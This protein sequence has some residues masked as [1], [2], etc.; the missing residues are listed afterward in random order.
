MET[1]QK[2][3]IFDPHSYG[4]QRFFP[5]LLGCSN[6]GLGAQPLWV[7]VFSTASYLQ[8]VWSLTD[9]I[10]CVLIYIIVQH[11]P[12][13]CGRHN[14]ALIQPVH[15]QGYNIL[16]FLDRMHLL[17]TL[18]HFLFWQPGRVGRQYAPIWFISKRLIVIITIFSMFICI[19]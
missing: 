7:L 19:F 8:L 3:N 10:S 5:V 15:G 11:P 4:H 9:L 12:S 1:K 6:G 17:F 13:S 2:C 14:F 16:I 18:V